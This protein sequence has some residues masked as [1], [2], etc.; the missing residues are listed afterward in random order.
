M[1]LEER[2]DDAYGASFAVPRARQVGQRQTHVHRLEE[3]VG[4]QGITPYLLAHLSLHVV[5]DRP[6]SCEGHDQQELGDDGS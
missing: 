4:E 1:R 6:G 5:G 3:L 2:G